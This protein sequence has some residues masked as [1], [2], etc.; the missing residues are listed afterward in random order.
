MERVAGEEIRHVLQDIE[1]SPERIDLIAPQIAHLI[2]G[3]WREGISHRDL[4]TK[5]FLVDGNTVAL[6][7]LDSASQH[8][9]GSKTLREKHRRDVRTF[10]N[11]CQPA[12]RLAAAVLDQLGKTDGVL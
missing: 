7:D 5:N 8:R 2:N 1:G 3:L 9:K 6:I 4:N 12:P 10:L 11:A